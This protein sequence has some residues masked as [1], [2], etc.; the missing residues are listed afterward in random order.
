VIAGADRS[1]VTALV[2]PDF[3]AC[4]RIAGLSKSATV[5]E[6]AGHAKVRMAMREQLA[7]FGRSATGSSNRIMRIA[8]QTEA[9]LLDTGEL[10]DKGSVSAKMVLKRRA[11]VVESLYDDE[12]AIDRAPDI[13]GARL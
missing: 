5:D 8:V 11:S 2:F 3:E 1:F 9:P 10:T 12:D 13:L 6:I 7:E 4:R